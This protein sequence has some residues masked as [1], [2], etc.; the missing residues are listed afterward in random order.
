MKTFKVS[1]D[2]LNTIIL[3][4]KNIV[5]SIDIVN[6]HINNWQYANIKFVDWNSGRY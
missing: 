6:F 3:S 2:T 4:A 1:I 5:G